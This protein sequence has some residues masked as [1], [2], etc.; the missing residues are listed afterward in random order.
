MLSRVSGL[1]SHFLR[2]IPSSGARFFSSWSDRA[3]ASN[4]EQISE[5]PKEPKL[6]TSVPGPVSQRLALEH[7]AVQ[8]P[9]TSHFFVDYNKSKGNY[10]VDADGNVLLDIF[11]QISSIPLGYNHPAL[12]NAAKSDEWVQAVINRPALGNLPPVSWPQLLRDSF[13]AVAPPGLNQVFTAMCGSCANECAYKAVFMMH[14]RKK[15]VAERGSPA[16]TEE[17]LQSCMCNQAPG[18]ANDAS[19]LSFKGGFHGR[20][21]GSLSSTRSRPLHK[22]DIPAFDW[23]VA[24]FPKLKYPLEEHKAEN[25]AEEAKCLAAVEEII[26]TWPKKVLGLIVEPVQAEGGDNYASDAFFRGLREITLKHNV[27]FIVDEVQTGGGS[28][29][30]FWAH[31]HWNLSTPPDIVTFSK[32]LQAAGFFH[33]V[34]L[35][36]SEG[37]RNFNTWMGD[38]VRALELKT[39]VKEIKEKKL[40]DNVNTTGAFLKQGLQELAKKYPNWIANVRGRGTFLAFD[41]PSTDAQTKL[42]SAMRNNGVELGGCGERSIR[43]RPM[44]TF[45]PRHAAQLLEILEKTAKQLS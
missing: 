18:S 39:V 2:G 44:L 33:N 45:Q 12:V 42:V 1:P 16:W 22:V 3:P 13:L 40:L 21:F 26:K 41:T 27:T 23:P 25:D 7:G 34:D 38:P 24:P 30:K 31:E 36:A 35:R 37:Y 43:I 6:A 10:I 20:L 15:R 4:L 29:G 32:K 8:D 19:I 9:R 28:T 17:E 5:E 14:A 11:C